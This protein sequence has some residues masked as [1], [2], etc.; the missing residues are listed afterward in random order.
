MRWLVGIIDSMDMS[1]CKLREM[2]KDREAWHAAVHG[3]KKS[4]TR[5]SNRTTIYNTEL[6]GVRANHIHYTVPIYIRNWST[7]GIWYLQGLLEPTPCGHRGAELRS[8]E[9]TAGNEMSVSL[10]A[11]SGRDWERSC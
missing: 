9:T 4:Q 5:L 7:H 6:A 1:H 2:V 3:V 8:L 10:N 11:L